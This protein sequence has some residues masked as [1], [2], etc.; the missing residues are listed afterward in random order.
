MTSREE[1]EQQEEAQSPQSKRTSTGSSDAETEQQPAQ[2]L[3]SNAHISSKITS[4]LCKFHLNK[5][6][7]M[8]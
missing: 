6:V 3:E 2:S 1:E 4:L 8:D 7:F 5:L